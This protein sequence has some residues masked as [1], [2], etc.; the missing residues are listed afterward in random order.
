MEYNERLSEHNNMKEQHFSAIFFEG[1]SGL[2]YFFRLEIAF[3]ISNPITPPIANTVR[4]CV[5]FQLL[6]P[7]GLLP[8]II[9]CCVSHATIVIINTKRFNTV[10]I[11]IVIFLL[12]VI[13]H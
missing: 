10:V 12:I 8:C 9:P 4:I 7:I 3:Q 2:D 13:S 6:M 1:T 5:E 11:A